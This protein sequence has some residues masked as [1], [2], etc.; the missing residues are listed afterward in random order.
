MQDDDYIVFPEL[1]KTLR[2]RIEE[3][4]QGIFLLPP[5]EH[6]SSRLRTTVTSNGIH[7]GFAWLGHGAMLHRQRILDFVFLLQDGSLGI[8]DEQMKMADNYFTVLNNEVPEIWFDQGIELGGG[9][10]FTVG[11]EGNERNRVHIVSST[12]SSNS[13]R[14]LYDAGK[15]MSFPGRYHS[16]SNGQ[17]CSNG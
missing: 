8:T 11:Q 4:S 15:R 1:I 17:R 5:H 7:T 6:L 3:S 12:L 13:C 9:Q 10:P 2:R 14:F 16:A